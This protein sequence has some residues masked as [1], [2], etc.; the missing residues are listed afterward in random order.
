MSTIFVDFTDRIKEKPIWTAH[1]LTR[2]AGHKD[3]RLLHV[4]GQKP[5]AADRATGPETVKERK[6]GRELARSIPIL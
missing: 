5:V 3:G 6:G 4:L 2:L 1:R